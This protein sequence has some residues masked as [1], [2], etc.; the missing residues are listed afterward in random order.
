MEVVM[1]III[2]HTFSS[3]HHS[4]K[5]QKAHYYFHSS[6]GGWGF[7]WPRPRSCSV[8][9]TDLIQNASSLLSGLCS[10]SIVEW[11][12]SYN[13]C[14]IFCKHYL[15]NLYKAWL[16]RNLTESKQRRH[17]W[18]TG[19]VRH[20]SILESDYCWLS[21]TLPLL[22]CLVFRNSECSRPVWVMST[23]FC[24]CWDIHGKCSFLGG[25]G[26]WTF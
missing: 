9:R 26:N 18:W 19:F 17:F 14:C 10:P 20:H 3:A 15:V 7:P 2:P 8:N 5:Q 23:W 13:T 21:V 4:S 22:M 25:W 6:A 24:Q 11:S 12:D 1:V 16:K